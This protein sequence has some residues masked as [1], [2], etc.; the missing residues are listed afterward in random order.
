M[1]KLR[2]AFLLAAITCALCAGGLG[3]RADDATADADKPREFTPDEV[4]AADELRLTLDTEQQTLFNGLRFLLRPSF[5]P[6]LMKGRRYQPCPLP[7]FEEKA[8]GP[9]DLLETLRFWALLQ[10]GMATTAS[11]DRMLDR[12]LATPNPTEKDTDNLA[13]TAI[14]ILALRAALK[15]DELGRADDIKRKAEAL[16]DL[17][18]SWSGPTSDRS[19]LVQGEYIAPLWFGNMMWRSL[20]MRAAIEFGFKLDDKQWEKDLRAL[21]AAYVKDR[22]WTSYKRVFN[23][24]SG[25]LHTNFA[26]IVAL[27]LADTAPEDTLNAT[28]LR[29]IGKKLKL[30]PE[31]LTRLDNDYKNE[32]W[33]G[34][35]IAL[36]N[37]LPDTYA[38]ERETPATWRAAHVRSGVAL[39]DATGRVASRHSLLV[40]IG[41][42]QSGWSRA[43]TSTC[44]T[45]LTCIGLSGGLLAQGKGPLAERELA[46]IGRILYAL[47]VLHADKARL[48]GGDF[49]SNVNYA[50][51]DGAA[52]LRSV[53]KAD[54]SFP[55]VY[56]SNPGNTAYCLLAMMHGGVSRDDECIKNGI[57]WMIDQGAATRASTYG[58]AAMLMCMQTY[59]APEQ[60]EAGI[61]Y[62]ENAKEFEE[63]RRKVWQSLDKEHATFIKSLVEYLD[64]ANVGGKRGGWGYMRAP[65]KGDN[66][67]SDNSCSQYA[68]LGYKAASLLGAELDT[69]VFE[70]EAERLISQYWKD[71]RYDPV[72]YIH[73]PDDRE[74]DDDERK[75]RKTRS[76]SKDNIR[77][78]GWS[79]ICGTVSGASMQ[80]TAAGIS[81]LTICMDEL[82]VR[83]KLKEALAMKI[84]LTIRGAEGWVRRNYYKPEN[85]NGST[86]PLAIATS[87]GWGIYYNLYSVERGCVLAGI[88]KL[89]GEVDWYQIGAEGLV[90]NQNM[91]GSWGTSYGISIPGRS[92]QQV[93]NTCLAILFLKRAAMPVITEHKK[94]EKEAEEE[95]KRKEAAK[96]PITKGPEDKK[97]EKEEAEKKEAE[98]SGE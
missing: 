93:I 94:R 77:P 70:A 41:L 1:F 15:R 2:N 16:I 8:D 63:A 55:G 20:I 88:R 62:I 71:E 96:N 48:G 11:S 86:S 33:N 61:L 21:L 67:H 17:T 79:Y 72:E 69:K 46:S 40:D 87:D 98:K 25:D 95:K 5:E 60:R 51:E 31:I 27:G 29:N 74:G 19:R 80:L 18:N 50:I 9:L 23:G 10:S 90:E 58:I 39:L 12:L 4:K 75:S 92:N 83:G 85:M 84:G 54:G 24:A 64:E 97:R 28:S 81:S 89:E 66:N 43:Q 36:L 49:D 73:N 3:V 59:Y 53:Q 14:R 35:R 22:G 34:S 7:P 6:E 82:K 13:P 91:D 57:K 30:V 42:A 32:T 45:A 76:S 78:G 68:V 47:A 37:T 65:N 38:P 56:E 44:E 52:F 26:S